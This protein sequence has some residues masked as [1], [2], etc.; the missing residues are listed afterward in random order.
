MKEYNARIEYRTRD[1]ID[2]QL[3]E[4]LT[5]YG[6]ATGRAERGWVEVYITVPA[7]SLRQA[8]TTALALAESATD[9]PVLAV[10]VL[11]TDEF[12]ARLG[13]AP[14]PELV[15]VTEA[16]QSLRVSRQAVLQRLESGTLPGRKVGNAW[17]IQRSAVVR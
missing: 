4:A 15:S 11:P 8:F 17:V 6:P 2:D 14:L 13:L 7:T 1:D 16:A 5:D 3:L 9:A 10:E 12:D